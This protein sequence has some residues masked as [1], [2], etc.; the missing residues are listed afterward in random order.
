MAQQSTP[1]SIIIALKGQNSRH[2]GLTR[3]VHFK[4]LEL[5]MP[6]FCC[7]TR[8]EISTK[9]KCFKILAQASQK[10]AH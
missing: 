6:S 5:K 4:T 1:K 2:F 3:K 9:R 8:A 7:L 10:F